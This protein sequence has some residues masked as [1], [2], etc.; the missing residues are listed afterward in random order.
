MT[1]VFAALG[2]PTRAAIVQRLSTQ[3]PRPLGA[4]V[5]GL[6]VTRQAATRHLYVLRDA[7]VIEV[8]RVGREQRCELS[9]ETVRRAEEWLRDL[10]GAWD[11]RLAAL[12]KHLD[13]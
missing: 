11:Q 13:G 2:E 9:L 1:E 8:K 3:G 5:E 12:Q 10:E 4:L 7:G 6:G